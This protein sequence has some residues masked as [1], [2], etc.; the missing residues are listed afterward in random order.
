MASSFLSP[1]NRYTLSD[2]V[3]GGVVQRRNHLGLA[4]ENETR[5]LASYTK[6]RQTFS[7]EDVESYPT[8]QLPPRRTIGQKRQP[9]LDNLADLALTRTTS[10]AP[11]DTNQNDLTP[12][13]TGRKMKVS[14]SRRERCRINQA[15]YRKRQRQHAENLDES[16]RTLQEEIRELGT[17]RQNILRRAPTNESV[18]I[19]ATEYFRLFRY[20]YIAPIMALESS[21]SLPTVCSLTVGSQR[22]SHAQL[23]FLKATMAPDVTDGNVHGVEAMLE[24]WKMLSL[25]GGDVHFQPKRLEQLGAGS[26]LATTK[27]S[28]T[29]TESSLRQLFPHLVVDQDAKE[30]QAKKLS[31]LA[32]KLLNQRLCVCGSVRFD[33]D[34]SI[35][36]VLRLESK[37]DLLSSM[38]TLLGSLEDVAL[39]FDKALV[40]LDGRFLA[41]ES[42]ISM[43]ASN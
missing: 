14:A 9:D 24:N 31:A 33:W 20:G 8:E 41:N 39:V 2:R 38:L 16:I 22:E 18:W 17:Q 7:F 6:P 25:N 36:R 11:M 32:A 10:V 43:P 4:N 13:T 42:V 1:P 35:G 12:P 34:T 3:I 28:V 29:I 27:M 37:A 30:D 5:E 23:E 40:T 26:L 19:I 21:T 15:R